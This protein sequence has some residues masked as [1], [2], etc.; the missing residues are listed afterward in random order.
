VSDPWAD[1]HAEGQAAP[2]RGPPYGPER[3]PEPGE[4][5][6]HIT[7]KPSLWAG[8]DIVAKA[9]MGI[10]L[11][12]LPFVL[13]AFFQGDAGRTIGLLALV[14]G[15]FD[16]TLIY[17][18]LA[19]LFPMAQLAFT[20]YV[21]DEEGIR[22]HV[23]LFNRSETRV[24]WEK[25]TLLRQRRTLVDRLFGIERLDVVAHG[26]RGTTLRLVGLRDAPRLRNLVAERMRASASV[27]S[28]LRSD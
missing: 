23:Q 5:G 13:S 11:V 20:R 27:T 28:L 17:A 4:E 7:L 10:L 16:F 8:L 26:V 12:A 21:V 22:V 25:I 6:G 3:L 14:V 24:A 15:G 2:P 18:T 19:A 1:F 9:V